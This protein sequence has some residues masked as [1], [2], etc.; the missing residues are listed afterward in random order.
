[1][2]SLRRLAVG[3]VLCALIA[4]LGWFGVSPGHSALRA[5]LAGSLPQKGI[6]V[7][8]SMRPWR[9]PTI[10]NP[11]SWW[12][13]P[14]NCNGVSDGTVFIN[15]EIPLLQQ[16]NVAMVRM[17]FPWWA[18]EKTAKGAFDWTRADYIVSHVTAAGLQLEPVLVWTPDWASPG[19]TNP[20]VS[21]VN[22][23][24]LQTKPSTPPSAQDF[25][26]F[27]RAI[28]SRYKASVHYWEMW[29]E[30]DVAGGQYFAGSGADYATHVLVPGYAAAHAADLSAQVVFGGPSSPDVTYIGSVLS[31]GGAG[32]FDI[33][34]YHAYAGT[35]TPTAV[36]SGAQNVVGQAAGKPLWVGE[37]GFKDTTGTGQQQV[38][39]A[40]LTVSSPLAMAQ[41]YELRDDYSMAGPSTICVAGTWGLTD[42]SY[43]KKVSFATFAALGTSSP[44]PTPTPTPS[45]LPAGQY[46]ALPPTRILDTRNG[47]GGVLAAPLGPGATLDVQ[48][49]GHGGVPTTG[50]SAVVLNVTT[51]NTSAASY[52]T[53]YPSGIGRPTASNLNWG[54]GKTVA[55]LVQVALGGGR[56]TL[57]NAFGQVDVVADVQGWVSTPV[58]GTAG[59][60]RPVVPAR[61]LDTRT[62]V[63]SSTLG[64]GQTINL[65]VSGAGPV[66]ATGVLGVVLNVTATNPTAAGY[67][68]AFPAGGV[69]PLASNLNFISGQTV[70]N[71]VVVKLGA[72]G[73]VSFFNWA[74]ATDL[75]VDVNG[76]FT[77]GSVPTATGGQFSGLTPARVLDTRNG[78]GGFSTSV[79]PGATIRLPVA[80]VGGVPAMGASGSPTAVVL[81]VTVTNTTAAGFLTVYPSDAATRPLASDLNW[82]RGLTV[83]NLVVVKLASDG[84]VAIFNSAGATDV[85]AD[86]VGW[87]N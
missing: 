74:G 62:G 38:M 61:L 10:E 25:G 1:M 67:V 40:V 22:P 86:V 87:Y 31:A 21:C 14:G 17:E 80:G 2:R 39:T 41:W 60:Y 5:A 79:G 59:L 48:V 57:Y 63:G 69:A 30:P 23:S 47:T 56:V 4:G 26:D 32:H 50:V 70:P 53:V 82:T 15:A 72:L 33:M 8:P 11:D 18:I 16:L 36:L 76:W 75:V 54:P 66:P 19:F 55:N 73:Q 68:T 78:T 27:V 29:N 45:L 24:N 37:W 34:S 65:Q 77:D 42:H 28:V 64:S 9:N 7:N 43:N 13:R 85:I 12:C 3:G 52:L 71:R 58:I 35:L 81:N 6:N 20:S 46:N 51:T 84:T 49:T 44:P 83:P